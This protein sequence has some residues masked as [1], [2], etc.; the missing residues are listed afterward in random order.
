MS[1]PR[2]ERQ[3]F[4]GSTGLVKV[5]LPWEPKIFIFRGSYTPYIGCVKP[6][7]F[8][9]FLGSNGSWWVFSP[10]HLSHETKP[11]YYFPLNSWLVKV[12]GS[13]FHGL[14]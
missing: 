9:G 4:F 10:T 3:K 8:H 12:P 5:I 7:F 14:L 11:T 6:S 2:R 13:L 1:P